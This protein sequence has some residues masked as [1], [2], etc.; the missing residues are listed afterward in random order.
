MAY[1]NHTGQNLS[2]D[3]WKSEYENMEIEELRDAIF[4]DAYTVSIITF[5]D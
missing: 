1:N 3:I 4:T 2:T 5:F